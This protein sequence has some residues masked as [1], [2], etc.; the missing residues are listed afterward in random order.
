MVARKKAKKQNI[1]KVKTI[2]AIIFLLI[3]I[4]LIIISVINFLPKI[5]Y[6]IGVLTY[7]IQNSPTSYQ[8][9]SF[10]IIGIVLISSC[11]WYAT[12]LV[13][14]R[15]SPSKLGWFSDHVVV[16][17]VI[18]GIVSSAFLLLILHL[19]SP[20]P[21]IS[22]LMLPSTAYE[23][24]SFW[25][26]NFY[27]SIINNGTGEASYLSFYV[28]TPENL[29]NDT[30]NWG[31]FMKDNISVK[32][33]ASSCDVENINGSTVVVALTDFGPKQRCDINFSIYSIPRN[34]LRL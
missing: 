30:V 28:V 19:T 33:A 9:L 17:A 8:Y 3:G 5:T 15:K 12:P 20:R 26:R 21:N 29:T 25:Y 11:L 10:A 14:K 1:S 18:T 24:Q 13:W 34:S 31:I 27:I 32:Y 16:T 22:I 2:L 6:Y 23:N 7:N 4:A